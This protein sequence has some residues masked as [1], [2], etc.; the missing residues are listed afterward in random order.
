ML[1]CFSLS[2]CMFVSVR[3]SDSFFK[4]PACYYCY[5]LCLLCNCTDFRMTI[6]VSERGNFKLLVLTEVTKTIH[7]VFLKTIYIVH[8]VTQEFRNFILKNLNWCLEISLLNFIP[9]P[10]SCCT[11][12]ALGM[13]FYPAFHFHRIISNNTFQHCKLFLSS[14]PTPSR[15]KEL[16]L[17]SFHI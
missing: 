6:N 1:I 2:E 11:G 8:L 12:P 9:S 16:V 3:M 15:Q 5:H 10:F 17:C 7:P 13:P 4:M 14:N